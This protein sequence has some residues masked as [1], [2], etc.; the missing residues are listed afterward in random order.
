MSTKGDTDVIDITP[1]VRQ[2]LRSLKIKSGIVTVSVVGST[3]ALT[4]CEFEPGLVQDLKEIF[5]KLIPRGHYHHDQAWGDGNAHSHL[6]ASLVGPSLT[7]PFKDHELIL[8]T[9]QQIIFLDFDN[10]RRERK[11]VAQFMG[12]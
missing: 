11:L 12:E 10:R 4:T 5:E 6:R 7:V 9:W 1:K 2:I 8:G 3:G